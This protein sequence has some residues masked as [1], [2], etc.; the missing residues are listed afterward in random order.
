MFNIDS[1]IQIIRMGSD[2]LASEKT[3]EQLRLIAVF[4]NTQITGTWHDSDY[5]HCECLFF[6]S[7][8]G[9][10]KLR[11]QSAVYWVDEYIV[12]GFFLFKGDKE[13]FKYSEQDRKTYFFYHPKNGQFYIGRPKWSWQK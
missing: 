11:S 9:K 4:E 5:A 13:A 8:N 6:D 12:D 7:M 2:T 10:F 3:I 1:G